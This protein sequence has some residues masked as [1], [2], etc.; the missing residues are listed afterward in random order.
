MLLDEFPLGNHVVPVVKVPGLTHGDKLGRA[1]LDEQ[2]MRIELEA[3]MPE[4]LADEVLC[5]EI[6]HQW[7][8]KSGISNVLSEAKC[9]LLC[10]GLGDYL[11][12]LVRYV[13]E[14]PPRELEAAIKELSK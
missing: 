8:F 12:Q 2:G 14:L 1:Q 10:D 7:L 13:R 4:A 5:H 11:A 6:I 3:A 9:E